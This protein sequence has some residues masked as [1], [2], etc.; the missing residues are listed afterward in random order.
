M[1]FGGRWAHY[2]SQV[3][4]WGVV[5]LWA[6]IRIYIPARGVVIKTHLVFTGLVIPL[7]ECAILANMWGDM[8]V[9]CCSNSGS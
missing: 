6:G 7:N 8:V 5:T 3:T 2:R 4:L 1:C 9:R